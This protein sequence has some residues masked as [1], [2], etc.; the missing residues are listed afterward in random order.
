MQE[1]PARG[2]IYFAIGGKYVREA[3]VSAR[4]VRKAM[5]DIPL[6]MF[7]SDEDAAM[8]PQGLFNMRLQLDPL[9]G[10]KAQKIASLRRTPF[11]RTLYLDADTYMACPVPE[12]FE[13]LD[14][15]DLAMAIA[16]L[17]RLPNGWEGVP[18]SFPVYNSGVI[19]Y[20]RSE[21]IADL[22][23]SWLEDHGDREPRDQPS[24][25]RVLYKSD[26][27]ITALGN[28]YNFLIDFPQAVRHEVKILHGRHGDLAG[29]AARVQPIAE[30]SCV[31][32]AAYIH[33]MRLIGKK[34]AKVRWT[35][36]LNG[37]LRSLRRS[38]STDRRT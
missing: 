26:A 2:I 11:D 27:R 22:W 18:S 10:I 16:S 35:E 29:L 5:P 13:M 20:R 37:A 4:S 36:I 12:L 9:L 6:A 23:D 19:A 17:G 21:T 15:F 28:A 3:I 24:L 25:R 14:N 1:R 7:A 30:V 33:K 38:G 8:I 32:P 34:T 31:L